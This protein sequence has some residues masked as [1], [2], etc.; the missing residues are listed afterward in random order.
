[1]VWFAYEVTRIRLI[2]HIVEIEV[3]LLGYLSIYGKN[4]FIFW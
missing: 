4:T 2:L 1:M 3:M